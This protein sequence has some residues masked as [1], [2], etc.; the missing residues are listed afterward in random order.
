MFARLTD[1]S[2]I[3]Y[4]NLYNAF[5]LSGYVQKKIAAYH[6]TYLWFVKKK[7]EIDF[8]A[9]TSDPFTLSFSSALCLS[10]YHCLVHHP[11][12]S[13]PKYKV[14]LKPFSKKKKNLQ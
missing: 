11:H 7:R 5:S 8:A 13:F 4:Q 9:S 12:P 6:F 1:L 10:Y 3:L 14:F 2:N